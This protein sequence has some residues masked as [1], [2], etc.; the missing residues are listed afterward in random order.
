MDSAPPRTKTSIAAVD[1]RI[2][3]CFV[4]VQFTRCPQQ[5]LDALATSPLLKCYRDAEHSFV[6]PSGMVFVG[7][8]EYNIAMEALRSIEVKPRRFFVIIS[9]R[10]VHIIA[11]IVKPLLDCQIKSTDLI[12]YPASSPSSSATAP[13]GFNIVAAG[14]KAASCV[15][16]VQVSRTEVEE[17]KWKAEEAKTIQ[18][19]NWL[20]SAASQTFQDVDLT[21]AEKAELQWW[22]GTRGNS[23]WQEEERARDKIKRENLDRERDRMW[24]KLDAEDKLERLRLEEKRIQDFLRGRPEIAAGGGRMEEAARCLLEE[25][26][27]C[28][29]SVAAELASPDAW[30]APDTGAAGS[31]AASCVQEVEEAKWKK[32]AEEHMEWGKKAIASGWIPPKTCCIA[33]GWIPPNSKTILEA[34]AQRSWYCAPCFEAVLKGP[35]QEAHGCPSHDRPTP[36]DAMPAPANIEAAGSSGEWIEGRC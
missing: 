12:L 25:L 10:D 30:P 4:L 34:A 33:S 16:A 21:D 29:N 14:S 1:P 36:P 28:R 6:L 13:G 9:P 7:D 18:Q 5:L 17:A 8:E 20:E 15:Q 22:L 26:A 2:P 35:P 19:K 11:E 23:R 31:K 32:K 3:G 24:K 27:R